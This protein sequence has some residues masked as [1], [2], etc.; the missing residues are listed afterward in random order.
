MHK[1]NFND[2]E[3]C[4]YCKKTFSELVD[5]ATGYLRKDCMGKQGAEEI[6][7]EAL[8]IYKVIKLLRND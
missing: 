5:G 1:H 2:T 6:E 3:K 7:K 8:I 4:I